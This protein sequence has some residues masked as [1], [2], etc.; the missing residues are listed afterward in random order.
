[1]KNENVKSNLID[2]HRDLTTLIS[3]LKDINDEIN[4]LSNYIDIKH[5]RGSKKV[6]SFTTDGVEYVVAW[7]G[8]VYTCTCNAFKYYDGDCKHIKEVKE[9]R[10]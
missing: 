6:S 2:I 3:N 5:P 10:Y 1:M 9:G 7:N 8:D 4:E